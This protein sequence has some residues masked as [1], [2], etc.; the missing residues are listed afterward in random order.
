MLELVQTVRQLLRAAGCG[1]KAGGEALC[2]V[3]KLA[4]AVVQLACRGRQ[5]LELGVELLHA[6]VQLARARAEL[7]CAILGL[8]GAGVE[9]AGAIGGLIHALSDRVEADEELFNHLRANRAGHGLSHLAT[10]HVAQHG[11][12][13]AVGFIQR[14]VDLGLVRVLIAHA[15]GGGGEVL[16]NLHGHVIGAVV[17][18]L[19]GF[20]GADQVEVHRG[21]REQLI[22]HLLAGLTFVRVD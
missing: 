18:A 7:T 1:G 20:V 17:H 10:G 4:H 3:I 2:A 11:W 12:D 21:L 15:G 13:K 14:D 22:D 5:P 19:A 16:G 8:F 9:L 6:V